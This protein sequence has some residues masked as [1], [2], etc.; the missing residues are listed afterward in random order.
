MLIEDACNVELKEGERISLECLPSFLYKYSTKY[1]VENTDKFLDSF[2]V[3]YF[4]TTFIKE[5]KFLLG[6]ILDLLGSSEVKRIGEPSGVG[7]VY[8]V[9]DKLG[10]YIVK[11]SNYCGPL[12]PIL[13]PLCDMANQGDIIYKIPDSTT[14]KLIIYAPNYISEGLISL[15]L[16][17]L[18]PYTPSFMKT[19]GFLYNN[20][21]ANKTTYTLMEPL[22][23]IYSVIK[24]DLDFFYACFQ[25]FQG[26][27][28]AQRLARFTHYDLHMGN[29]LSR[30]ADKISIYPLYNG[31]YFYAWSVNDA[32]IIDYGYSRYETDQDIICPRLKFVI[33]KFNREIMDSAL[34]NPYYDMF[35]FIYKSYTSGVEGKFNNWNN[36]SFRSFENFKILLKYLLNISDDDRIL[37]LEKTFRV[38]PDVNS[39]RTF[40]E[41]LAE[42]NSEFRM[43]NA[44]EMMINI[45]DLLVPQPGKRLL[46]K[47]NITPE[48]IL[49][50]LPK[51]RFL[52]LDRLVTLPNSRIYTMIE[53]KDEMNTTYFN[54]ALTP[55]SDIIEVDDK[56]IIEI[57]SYNPTDYNT[58]FKDFVNTKV[59]PSLH[60][61]LPKNNLDN[62][63]VH[64]AYINQK[65]GL[66]LG[67]EYKLDC[68]R[69]DM[70]HIFQ[71]KNVES[72]ISVNASFFRIKDDYVPVGYFKSGDILVDNPIPERF[73]KYYAGVVIDKFGKLDMVGLADVKKYDTYFV[74]GPILVA[75]STIITTAEFLNKCDEPDDPHCLWK[76]RKARRNVD[77]LNAYVFPDGLFNCDKIQNGDLYHASNPNPRTAIGT[78]EN[79]NVVIIYVEGR[80][81]RGAGMDLAQLAQLCLA[82]GCVNALNLDGG[83]SSNFVWKKPGEKLIRYPN[84]NHGQS[85]PVGA[86]L[87][88]LK[89]K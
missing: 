88:F 6:A 48:M 68:C 58:T 49:N 54:Y 27:D 12:S 4:D 71:D 70:R 32:V 76:C 74:S 64:I 83:I 80:D 9:S 65:V 20:K 26:L 66:K 56:S 82:A 3:D 21:S 18:S 77:D 60:L 35:G 33:S 28:T 29:V 50:Y 8:K 67:F 78:D 63:Y 11:V 2:A 30:P 31:Q 14:N 36:S 25:V 1:F 59:N 38:S 42:F 5:N 52:I 72:G 13:T 17:K 87:S 53:P 7:Q 24:S 51:Y 23:S 85:Y 40:P 81:K 44:R 46:H 57:M 75:N 45:S 79:G 41:I 86:T 39:W 22:G 89:Y 16:D 55:D 47:P 61:E 10:G 15:L 73:E 62:Q 34:F 69:V 84:P 37:E 43:S 19:Y